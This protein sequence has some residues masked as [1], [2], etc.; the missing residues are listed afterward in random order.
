VDKRR[1]DVPDIWLG[2]DRP[3][4]YR[5]VLKEAV[6]YIMR[7]T[8]RDNFFVMIDYN[9]ALKGNGRTIIEDAVRENHKSV[10]DYEET[11]SEDHDFMQTHDFVAGALYAHL[12]DKNDKWVS[13]LK[14]K[15]KRLERRK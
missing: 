5:M 11:N 14:M 10:K 9:T 15:I 7:N 2:K 6:R 1:K 12:V 4:A 3:T 13:K 8:K